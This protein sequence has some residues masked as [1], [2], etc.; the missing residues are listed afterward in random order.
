MKGYSLLISP[1]PF[2]NISWWQQVL[3]AEQVIMDLGHNYQK[4]TF[5]NRYEIGSAGGRQL[6]SI[7]LQQGRNQRIPMKEVMISYTEN[8]QAHQWK[9]LSAA[10]KRTP[11]FEFYDYN[12]IHLFQE[13]IKHLWEW[14]WESIQLIMQLLK[15]ENKVTISE[16]YIDKNDAEYVDLRDW[17]KNSEEKIPE[18]FSTY[19]QPFHHNHSF[20]ANLSILDLLFCEGPNAISFLRV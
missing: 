9:S 6:L 17:R 12:L 10:Y 18:E 19:I 4:M 13:N 20:Q 3:K 14:N 5:R 15:M 8:W 16:K 1:M 11:F 2:P 7:P